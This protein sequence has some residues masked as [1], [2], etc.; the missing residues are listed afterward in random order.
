MALRRALVGVV[1][2]AGKSAMSNGGISDVRRCLEI[3]FNEGDEGC[4]EGD[5]E[6]T[7]TIF[8]PRYGREPSHLYLN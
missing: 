8:L 6:F 1:G 7:E 2:A 4:N 3:E 5:E